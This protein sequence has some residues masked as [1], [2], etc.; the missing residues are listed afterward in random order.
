[1]AFFKHYKIVFIFLILTES[2]LGGYENMIGS[3]DY[4]DA[5][6]SSLF[7]D[8]FFNTP[9]NS[10]QNYYG[11]C[12]RNSYLFVQLLRREGFDISRDYILYFYTEKKDDRIQLTNP[13]KGPV[14]RDSSGRFSYH[15]VT[16]RDGWIYDFD[17]TEE[18]VVV[19]LRSYL[20]SGFDT[21]KMEG[22]V[23]VRLVPAEYYLR[24]YRGN[25]S[26]LR[27]DD[28]P[29]YRIEELVERLRDNNMQFHNH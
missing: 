9:G 3:P 8:S 25:S 14:E 7:N 26:P 12:W 23:M 10:S 28:N 1:M 18:P 11:M 13:R 2:A 21:S 5:K 19:S 4:I 29:A 15:V 27:S 6:V 17:Y 24:H 20:E 22:S 16:Y